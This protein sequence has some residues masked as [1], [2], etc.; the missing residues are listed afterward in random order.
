[1]FV[2]AEP[3][4][5]RLAGE[6]IAFWTG[7]YR[8]E[9]QAKDMS[10]TDRLALR[11][12]KSAVIVADLKAWLEQHRGTLAAARADQQGPQLP[13]QPVGGTDAIP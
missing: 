6:A 3:N 13:A 1:M 11:R 12:E 8:I 4:H 9:K 5:R 7:L 10:P 2:D